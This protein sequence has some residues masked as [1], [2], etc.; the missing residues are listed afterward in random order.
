MPAKE[1][2]SFTARAVEDAK[3]TIFEP[4]PRRE[5]EDIAKHGMATSAAALTPV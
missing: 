3:E 5:R 4:T 2:K 1:K